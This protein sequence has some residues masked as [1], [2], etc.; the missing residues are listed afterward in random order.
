LKPLRHVVV[1]GADI[2]GASG[3]YLLALRGGVVTLVERRIDGMRRLAS[4]GRF[5]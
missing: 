3:G 1:C 5:T 2:V 4:R